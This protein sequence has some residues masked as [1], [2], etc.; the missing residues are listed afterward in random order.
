M[1]DINNC[2]KFQVD[3][4]SKLRHPNLVTLVGVCPEACAI[5]YEYNPNG[6]LE[7]RLNC[8]GN[9][10]PLSWKTRICIATDLCSALMFLHSSGTV[11]GNL[12]AENIFLDAGFAC[13]LSGFGVG[14]HPHFLQ[15]GELSPESDI[16]SFGMIIIQL[17]TGISPLYSVDD[18]PEVLC[19][20][21]LRTF[22]DHSAGEWPF[23]QATQLLG[24]ALR[25]CDDDPSKRPDLVSEISRFLKPIRASCAASSP[26]GMGSDEHNQSPSYFI[27]PILQV[28]YLSYLL[29]CITSIYTCFTLLGVMLC[30]QE[31]MQNPVVAADG[32]TYEE[33]ALRGWLDTGHNTSPMTNLQLPHLNLVPN[34]TLRSAIQ[35]WIQNN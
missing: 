11:H 14:N 28:N 8:K 26:I 5:A 25:C 19:T 34:R 1:S 12:K 4:L 23:V 10:L 15:T 16:Y 33:E 9:T 18:L 31:V 2:R 30:L 13:K 27:C 29:L 7:D 24:L 22:L 32:Y 35:E 21:N 6:T 17:L 20:E 3:V